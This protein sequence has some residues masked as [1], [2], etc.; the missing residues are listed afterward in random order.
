SRL[1]GRD[2]IRAF[3]TATWAANPLTYTEYRVLAIHDTTDP[4][5]IIVEQEAVG[6]HDGRPFALPNLL[7]LRVR[8]GLITHNRDY[9]HF[10]AAAAALG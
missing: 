4:E 9:V 7:V 10:L 1:E 5:V 2:D 8:D 3:L 6:T